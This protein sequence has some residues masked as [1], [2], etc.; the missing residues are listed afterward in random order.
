MSSILIPPKFRCRAL[1]SAGGM[2]TIVCRFVYGKELS[3]ME[4]HGTVQARPIRYEKD[5]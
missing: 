5:E 3:R 2:Y 1:E 4:K